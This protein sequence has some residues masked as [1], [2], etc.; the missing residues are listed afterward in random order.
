M[1]LSLL[2]RW[3]KRARVHHKG[4]AWGN[5]RTCKGTFS[6]QIN[7]LGDNDSD[8]GRWR[9]GF[10]PD[11]IVDAQSLEHVEDRARARFGEATTLGDV[12]TLA[13]GQAYSESLST[14]FGASVQKRAG[15]VHEDYHKAAKKLDAKLGTPASA[16]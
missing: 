9:Q 13:P 14:D 12:K 3:S 11:L 10:I 15:K 5:P 6:E 8:D 4:G 16:T 1:I 7:R 2:S